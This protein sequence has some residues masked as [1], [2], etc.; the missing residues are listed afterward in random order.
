MAFGLFKIIKGILIREAGT[1]TP[2]EIEIT[3]GGTA[4]TK[5]TIASSQTVARTLTLPDATTTLLGTN[6]SAIVTNKTIDADANTITNIENADIKVGAAIDAA[7]L[8]D[9]S[10]SNTEFQFL[11]GVSS[12]IQT[13]LNGKEPTITTLPISK[14]GTNSGTALNNNRNI[15][16]SGG[17]IVES[18]A[19]TANRALISDANG[20]PT[21]SAV[22]NTELGFVSGVTSAIQTQLDG[23]V[24]ESLYT[25][26]GVILAASA[27]NTP[28]T[29]PVGTN[30]QVLTADSAE[31]TGVKWAP[32]GTTSPLTTKGDLYTY[33]TGN[34]RLPVGTNGQILTVDSAEATGIKWAAAAATGANT[35]LSNLTSPTAI[36]QDLLPGTDNSRNVGSGAARFNTVNA[37]NVTNTGANLTLSSTT[38]KVV[39][40]GTS[41]NTPSASADPS[42]P[43]QDDIYYNTAINKFKYFDGTN[44]RINASKDESNFILN[45]YAESVTTGWA[46][47]N[48]TQTVT[49]TIATPAVFTVGSTTGFYVGMPLSLSTTGALPTGLAANTDY[50]ISNVVSGTTFRVSTTLGGADINTTG[51]QSGVHTF[52]PGVPITATGGSANV[53]F[54]ASSTSP[55]S[56]QN[57]FIFTKD[58]ANREGEGASYSFTIDNASKSKVLQIQFDSIVNSGTFAAGGQ[59]TD[60]DLT[61]YIYDVTNA[62]IIQPTTYKI[63]GGSTVVADKFVS[64]FQSSA[65]STSY[66]L[67][68][69]CS[70]TSASAYSLKIDNVVVSPTTFSY[71]TPITDWQTYTPTFTAMGTVTA[72][73]AYWARIGSD[74][75]LRGRFTVGTTVAS[76]AR[77]SLPAGLVSSSQISTAL[78][79][80]GTYGRLSTSTDHGGFILIEPSVGYVTF[81]TGAVFGS[82]ST[83]ALTKSTGNNVAGTGDTVS[84]EARIPIAGW[85]AQV[86]S[87][88]VNDQRIVA[89]KYTIATGVSASTVTPWNAATRVYDTHSAVTTGSGWRFTAPISGIY[90]IGFHVYSGASTSNNNVYKNGTLDGFVQ[91][92]LAATAGAIGTYSI[93]LVAGDFIDVRPD[94]SVT[95][96]TFNGQISVERVANPASITSTETVAASYWA[97][98][99]KSISTTTPADFD[100]KDYDTHNAVTIGAAWKF[101][102]PIRGIYS[103]SGLINGTSGTYNLRLYKNGVFYKA[104]AYVASGSVVGIFSNAIQLNAGDFIDIRSN[105]AANFAGGS[106]ATDG[107][108]N[109]TIQKI[110]I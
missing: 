59:L 44:W 87:S 41:I 50:F 103:L 11:D 109:I 40:S 36:N 69:H 31:A 24:D 21:Q 4:N 90:R 26:K 33:A 29:L 55:L 89:A 71:G 63:F 93:S 2:R 82:G 97:S 34:A 91:T 43:V 38:G 98:S 108:S 102:A 67:I 96:S 53:T 12:N 23:K 39:L 14:G 8:A 85:S 70:T 64:N 83:G 3:P 57:S 105:G 5:T 60:S 81:S 88:D 104:I 78:E 66:R 47:Y 19:I 22:T 46:T 37:Q 18:A 30:G 80:S 92:S 68:F 99:N 1:N 51:T 106:L 84:F 20:I 32:A 6:N 62:R 79:V 16:S 17:Q 76:E 72:I 42:S 48:Q 75:V 101:T 13:Q 95:S 73:T 54:T 7:K 77:L 52:R 35:T 86:Q 74:V 49:V 28:A 15:V 107:T 27:A 56:D 10:I 58:A 45:G 9:G 110:G 61:V 65:D 25:A 94:A 100:S